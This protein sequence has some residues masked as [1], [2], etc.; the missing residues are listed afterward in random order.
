MAF[1]QALGRMHAGTVGREADFAALL[2][3]AA[4]PQGGRLKGD[5]ITAQAHAAVAEV[6][7]LLREHLGVTAPDEVLELVQR[8]E[9]LFS[10]GRFRAFSPSDLCPENVIANERGIRF[11]DYEW[12]GFR[13]ATLDIAYALVSFPGCLCDY[14]LSRDRA[15]QM[16][17]AWRAEVAGVWPAL[18][19][20]D[21]LAR[22]ILEARLMW[23]W[24]TTYW[25]LPGDHV[26][27]A[28]A[29][30]HGLSV[31]RS[32]ALIRRW[33]GLAEDARCHEDDTLADFADQVTAT[34]AGDAD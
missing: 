14:E 17:D 29:R 7:G 31:P 19:D 28:S 8:C 25:F 22:R 3:R 12:G 23:L 6:P 34:M 26:R 5:G 33:A 32:E 30:E 9:S 24:L 20:D 10:G 1:A 4:G 15:R 27:I 18:G 16:A 11:L 13:D 21:L 2:H